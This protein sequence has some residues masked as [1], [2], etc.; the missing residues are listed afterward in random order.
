MR[1]ENRLVPPTG[2]PVCR[3]SLCASRRATQLT[4]ALQRKFGSHTPAE[5]VQ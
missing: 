1:P 3:C 5:S 4:Q 2:S